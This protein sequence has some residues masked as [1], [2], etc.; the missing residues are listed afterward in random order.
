MFYTNRQV[1]IIPIVLKLNAMLTTWISFLILKN[2]VKTLIAN[3]KSV[4]YF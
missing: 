1:M 4:I 3:T 2:T